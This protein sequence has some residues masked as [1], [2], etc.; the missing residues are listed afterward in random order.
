M[1][2]NEDNENEFVK[3]SKGECFIPSQYLFVDGEDYFGYDAIDKSREKNL[4]TIEGIKI[5][6][7]SNE[8][9]LNYPC[10]KS[11]EVQTYGDILRKMLRYLL[12]LVQR[13][14]KD[15]RMGDNAIEC[16][17]IAAPASLSKGGIQN[18]GYNLLLKQTIMD[19]THLDSNHVFVEKEPVMAAYAY[20]HLN[21][22][23]KDQKIFV[24]DL[25]GGTLDTSI[26]KYTVSTGMIDVLTVDG[27]EIGGNNWTQEL[28]NLVKEQGPDNGV[29]RNY[30]YNSPKFRDDIE[31]LKKKLSN[32]NRKVFKIY[33]E[34]GV[35]QL[36]ISCEDFEE[37][38]SDL[39]DKCRECV[40][41]TIDNSPFR[42]DDID[43]VLLVGGSSRMPQI[44]RMFSDFPG[45][46]NNVQLFMPD[47]AISN[48]C[49]LFSKNYT[50]SGDI[51]LAPDIR[52]TAPH[53]YGVEIKDLGNT[54][55]VKNIIFKGDEYNEGKI[56][57]TPNCTFRPMNDKINSELHIKVYESNVCSKDCND[58]CA[59][60]TE[61]MVPFGEPIIIPI[62]EE[63]VNKPTEFKIRVVFTLTSDGI[64]K[65][66]IKNVQNSCIIKSV[67]IN[68]Q[69]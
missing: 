6:V 64:L 16:I 13:S 63:Y 69:V 52:E 60:L 11:E 14:C 15:L 34:S 54:Q 23:N 62:P 3:D 1:I 68:S 5:K 66:S 36:S 17:T 40:C 24:F 67:E 33:T 46:G 20:F 59:E 38:T 21:N 41:R 51:T 45:M 28:L 19:Y 26:V 31:D 8:K 56:C 32:I 9:N 55:L 48:G 27:E 25:G 2:I 42:S 49:A 12:S 22:P 44:K 35:K 47:M 43:L 50:H 29:P 30:N 61:G 7:R 65:V 37:A 10:G 4:P 57:K 39:L 18:A 58:G 53:S